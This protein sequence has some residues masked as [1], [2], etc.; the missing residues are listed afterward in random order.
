MT[1]LKAKIGASTFVY[2][3]Y[4]L[5]AGLYFLGLYTIGTDD[6]RY[7]SKQLILGFFAPP[8]PWYVGGK[9]AYRYLITTPQYRR[10]EKIC[11]DAAQEKSVPRR[12]RLDWCGCLAS[13]EDAKQC[14]DNMMKKYLRMRP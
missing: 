9:T 10:S 14:Q 8:Y 5:M 12:L 7:S 2:L 13:G 3:L 6:H 1:G 4:G 11:L